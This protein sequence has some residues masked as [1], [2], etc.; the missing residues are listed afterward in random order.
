[1]RLI[2]YLTENC[3]I[4]NGLLLSLLLNAKSENRPFVVVVVVL[5]TNFLYQVA[6]QFIIVLYNH[7]LIM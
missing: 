1:M 2:Y 6:G 5:R 3:P 4:K 7:K